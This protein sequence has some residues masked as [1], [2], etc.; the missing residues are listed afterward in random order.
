MKKVILFVICLFVGLFVQAQIVGSYVSLT[1]DT[2][3]DVET[4]YMVKDTPVPIQGNYTVGIELSGTNSSGTATVTA[5]L[6][7]S[8]D[9][10]LWYNYGSS[11]TLNNAGTVSNYAWALSESAFKYYRVRCISS[12]TGVTAIKGKLGL[13]N[14]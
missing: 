3:T 13:K 8:D 1:N 6:Q 12:G 11:I 2:T 9:N 5:A 10:T 7:V 14:K 4:V